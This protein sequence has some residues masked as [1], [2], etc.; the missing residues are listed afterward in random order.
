MQAAYQS[1]KVRFRSASTIASENRVLGSTKPE[2]NDSD[3]LNRQVV[4][5][6]WPGQVQGSHGNRG[7]NIGGCRAQAQAP[8]LLVSHWAVDS[9]ATVKLITA[10]IREI[11]RDKSM[12]RAEALRRA[13]LALIDKGK[14]HEAHQ[15]AGRGT[16]KQ[17]ASSQITILDQ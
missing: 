4:G 3:T 9:D 13:V 1:Q 12:G 14:P 2:L 5:S 17:P 6:P 10:A 7:A 15:A 16:P 11:A 8:A